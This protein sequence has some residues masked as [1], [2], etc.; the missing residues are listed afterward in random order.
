M[1]LA[2]RRLS[3]GAEAVPQTNWNLG[4]ENGILESGNFPRCDGKGTGRDNVL[5]SSERVRDFLSC[6]GAGKTWGLESFA[7]LLKSHHPPWPP[8]CKGGSSGGEAPRVVGPPPP[9]MPVSQGRNRA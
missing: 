1:I 6:T 9:L 4:R 2:G 7:R 3:A 5:L 8:L